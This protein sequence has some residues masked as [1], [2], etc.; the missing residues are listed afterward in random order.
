MNLNQITADESQRDSGSKARVAR[1]ELPWGIV[2]MTNSTPTG[3]RSARTNI[4]C[5][6]M[7]PMR[8]QEPRK[9]PMNFRIYRQVLDCG[10]GVREV[11]ALALAALKIP[12][13]SADKAATPKTL[14]P[15]SKTLT[16]RRT[17]RVIRYHPTHGPDARPILEVEATQGSSFLA[18]LGWRTQSR[19]DCPPLTAKTR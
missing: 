19:W 18:T 14:S 8:G 6:F 17:P 12:K 7:V 13:R 9:L 2:A 15:Q 11:T 10:D 1:H 4:K 5:R 3:L 16:R